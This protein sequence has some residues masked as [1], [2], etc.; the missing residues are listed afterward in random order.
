MATKRTN[1]PLLWELGADDAPIA[2]VISPAIIEELE[3]IAAQEDEHPDVFPKDAATDVAT[4][5]SNVEE[6]SA[7]EEWLGGDPSDRSVDD[8]SQIGLFGDAA[9]EPKWKD[10]WVG[11]PD[12]EQRDLSPWRSIPVHFMNEADRATFAALVGQQITERTRSI[13]FPKA[14]IARMV[15]KRFVTPKPVNPKYPIYIISKGRWETRLTAKSLEAMSVPYRIVIEPQDYDNYAAVINPAKILVLPFS[16]LGQGSI[17]ARNWVWEHSIKEGHARHWILDDNIDG[18]Y[19]L[20]QNLKVPVNT[21]AT[22]RACEEFSDRFENVVES[23]MNYFMFASRKTILPPFTLNTRI[24][25]CILLRNDVPHRWRG[26]YNED[27]DLSIR[28]L[29]D[30]YC[31]IL[32]NAFLAMKS[33]TMTMKGGNTEE[34]YLIEDGRLKMAESLREQHP[35]IVMVTEKWGRPQHHVDYSGF[36]KN[37][38]V[39]KQGARYEGVNNFGMELERDATTVQS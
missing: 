20:F 3:T 37:R 1:Q 4:E 19:R 33:T 12:F 10:L 30:G 8:D 29:K 15:D 17:P 34:L 18:F 23:G 13:W 16:N 27:T 21:G 31:T 25:S 22:F 14:D 2:P 7:A 11:M 6:G 32:F 38:L 5:S 36:R 35:E 26:R 39:P 9:V 28:L 24:Y